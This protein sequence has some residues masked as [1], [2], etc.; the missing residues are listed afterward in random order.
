M[1][2]ES[3]PDQVLFI[4]GPYQILKLIGQGGIGE[5]FLAYDTKCKRTVA[6]KRLRTDIQ[7]KASAREQ[8]INEARYTSLLTHPAIIPILSIESEG[9]VVYYTM[10]FI[11]GTTLKDV[12][13]A[14]QQHAD[15][16]GSILSLCD[17]FLHIC[18]AVA[19][20]HSKELIHCD[21]KPS[22]IMIGSHG[23][24]T[25]LDWGL[26]TPT[27]KEENTEKPEKVSGTMAYIA[28]ELIYGAS[29]SY[30]AEIYSLGMILYQMLTLRHPFH[31]NTI[32]EY[33]QKIEK[34]VLL[35]PAEVAPFRNIPP[36]LSNIALKCLAG[37][38]KER[39]QTIEELLHDLSAF[40]EGD[41]FNANPLI[42]AN[43]LL[44]NKQYPEALKEYRKVS[45]DYPHTDVG[46]K[47]LYLA[48]IALLEK[49]KTK[50]STQAFRR[51][52]MEFEKLQSTDAGPL[53]YL[54]KAL[55][56]QAQK[57]IDEEIAIFEHAFHHYSQHPL[58]EDL[59]IAL[60]RRLP[61]C[62]AW[63]RQYALRLF[64]LAA[65][66]L[67]AQESNAETEK[68]LIDFTNQLEPFFF[69]AEH[70]I[71]EWTPESRRKAIAI[72]LAFWLGKSDAIVEIMDEVLQTSPVLLALIQN[73]LF[74][75]LE[76]G[77]L[78]VVDKKL[79]TLFQR[80]LDVQA[81]AKLELIYN[82]VL[83]HQQGFTHFDEHFFL[84][85]P[86]SLDTENLQPLW[87]ILETALNNQK[88]QIVHKSAQLLQN[89]SL[90]AEQQLQLDCYR[91]WAFLLEDEQS[92]SAQVF[93]QYP[94]EEYAHKAL[95]LNFLYGCW[96]ALKSGKKTALQHL[97]SVPLEE[98]P[99]SWKSLL[100]VITQKKGTHKHDKHTYESPWEKRR[101]C[102][103]LTLFYHC[104]NN[105]KNADKYRLFEQMQ[106]K[107]KK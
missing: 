43:T 20:A 38:P 70:D 78:E 64:L 73:A 102:R 14:T 1:T 77:E 87:H 63:P 89:H 84:K 55:I 13:E 85:M 22:N 17:I 101:L 67:P 93:E 27:Q 95:S 23:E 91:I 68:T 21:L 9:D 105:E 104:A 11:E 32:Q 79:N 57:K 52:F 90:S 54:G 4:F 8:F 65:Q 50:P 15:T 86:R 44:S 28:P 7:V 62:T 31:R 25:I 75:L 61:E 30:Q 53:S 69:L 40:I 5:V 16:R 107:P 12:L 60:M 26:V 10:P 48:G 96:L 56:Y 51:A 24:V 100:E 42:T 76:L 36:A 6:L 88:T 103:R 66:Y 34:E 58:M 3:T 37:T 59:Q 106:Y 99:N 74:A 45:R 80:F 19:Y 72:Q 35:D 92:A 2:E 46:R 33:H 98:Q 29:P 18:Q 71:S 97:S 81:I 83:I 49:A 41:N 94:R 82:A 47:A 39:Y